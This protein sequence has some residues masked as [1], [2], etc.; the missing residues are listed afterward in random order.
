MKPILSSTRW[1]AR[2]ALLGAIGAAT[3]AH[4]PSAHAQI[5]AALGKPLPSPDLPVGTVSVRVVAGSAAAPIVGTTVTLTVND[6]PREART[7]SAGRASFPGLPA[8]ATV[9]AKVV[10]DDKAEHA[11]EPFTIPDAGGTRLMITTKPWQGGAGGGAPFAGGGG[12]GMPEPRQLS[13]EARPEPQDPA[14]T[15]TVRVTYDDFK[16]T[17]AD[18]PVA[19]VGYAADDTTSILTVKTDKDGRAQFTGLDRSGGTSYFAIAELP[20]NGG[21]DRLTSLP[22]MLDSQVGVRL[23]LSTVKRDSKDPTIDDLNKVDQQVDTP[24]GKVRVVLEGIADVTAQ[25]SLVDAA[26]KKVIGEAK[27]QSAAPDASR[28]SGRAQFQADPSLPAGTVD[29]EVQGGPGQAMEPLKDV[30]VQILPASA[31]DLTGGLT[32]VTGTDGTV[33]MS[34]QVTE[35][36]KA[37]LTINGRGIASQPFEI[38]KG[39]GKLTVRAQWPESGRPEA[40]FGLSDSAAGQPGQIVYAEASFMGQH[41]RSLPFALLPQTGSKITIYAFPRTLFRFQ[42]HAFV[43]DELLAVQGR[44]TIM[45]YSWAPYR[46][47]P[48]GLIIPLPK[49]FKGGVVFDPDQNEVSV[50]ADEGFRVIRPIPPGERAFHGGFSLPI[51]GGKSDWALDLPMGSYESQ[52]DIRL[53]TQSMTVHAPANAQGEVKTIPQGSYYVL[54]NVS[55]RPKQ[56]MQMTIEGMPSRSPWWAVI[57]RLVGGLVVVTLLGGLGFALFRTPQARATPSGNAQRRQRLLEELVEL[58]RQGSNLPRATLHGKSRDQILD[59]LEK[60]WD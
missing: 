28:V 41:Y 14:G 17:P 33:R 13:G 25:V 40:M 26:S 59:E 42:L 36:Q 16:D 46:A 22:I 30:K 9:I 10:D 34:L 3:V 55:I 11:S 4:A 27:P 24:A 48:D 12:G 58:E 39:G 19:L 51:S 15:I 7:D 57:S 1:L 56:S 20:R 29:V 21:L 50:T 18:V 52:M 35:P 43:E 6:Q 44:F 47:G 45:N 60:I 23:V 8:G 2:V 54:D 32:S 5:A 37:V 31:R 38:T 53:A 49:G